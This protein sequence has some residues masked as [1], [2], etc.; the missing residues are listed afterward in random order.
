M[1][2]LTSERL[3][4]RRL[5]LD[6]AEFIVRLLNDPDFVRFIGD[7]G[8]RTPDDA[9]RYLR[10]GPLR[11]YEIHGFGLWA[12][13]LAATREPLGMSGLLKRDALDDVEVGFAFLPQARRQGYAFE[14]ARAVLDYGRDVHGLGR[15]VAITSP[16]NQASIGLLERLGLRFERL[17]RLTQEGE[18][19]ELFASGDS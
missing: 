18:E 1:I 4:L 10:D 13:E 11:S 15:I 16:D 17:L 14:A 6:D 3:I 9:R 19:L 7:R 12:V 2:V 5:T 8:V